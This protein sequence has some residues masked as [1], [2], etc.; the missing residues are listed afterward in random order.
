MHRRQNRFSLIFFCRLSLVT[1]F[2]QNYLLQF[3]DKQ[4][5]YQKDKFYD[6]FQYGDC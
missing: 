5:F 3:I 1:V 4:I 6:E 2:C